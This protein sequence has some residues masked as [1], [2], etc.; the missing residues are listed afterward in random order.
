MLNLSV[1][2]FFVVLIF[3]K[4]QCISCNIDCAVFVEA[5]KLALNLVKGEP[6]EHGIVEEREMEGDEQEVTSETVLDGETID[7]AQIQQ[8]ISDDE[9]GVRTLQ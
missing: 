5:G 3:L 6:G 2:A 9:T 8:V 4:T 1:Q 7:G